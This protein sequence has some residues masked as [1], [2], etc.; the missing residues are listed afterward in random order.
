MSKSTSPEAAGA[1]NPS[2][3]SSCEAHF[4]TE[5]VR[6]AKAEVQKAQAAYDKVRSQAVDRLKS[7][8]EAGVGDVIDKTLDTV[9]RHPALSIGAA[10]L[11]GYYIGRLFGGKK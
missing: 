9:K 2:A 7:L 11:I 10:A 5:A 1:A 3:E 8:R 6:A 4:A